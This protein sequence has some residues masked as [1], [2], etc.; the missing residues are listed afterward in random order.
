[1]NPDMIEYYARRARE[2]EAIYHH[3]ER[4]PDLDQ[5]RE[6]LS[7]VFSGMDVLDVACGTG[8]WTEYIAR[9]AK[10]IV[11]TDVS[12]EVME[13]AREKN[14]GSCPVQFVRADAYDLSVIAETFPACFAGFFWSHIPKQRRREFLENLHR[15]LR[16][17]AK[18]VMIDNMFVKGEM[19]ELHRSDEHG[20]TYRERKLAD[21]S[22]YEITKNYPTEDEFRRALSGLAEVTEWREYK[23]YWWA[24]YK[25]PS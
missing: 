11:A 24:E 22:T 18:V 21:G 16:P 23:Y 17:G 13:L 6:R 25:L 20:N 5:L 2:Y 7:T 8:Y 3:P 9:S 1:M 14:Y 19:T 15:R 12:E 10:S 4:Q